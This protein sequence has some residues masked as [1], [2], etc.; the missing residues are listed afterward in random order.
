VSAV[1][2]GTVYFFHTPCCSNPDLC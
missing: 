1:K 2:N